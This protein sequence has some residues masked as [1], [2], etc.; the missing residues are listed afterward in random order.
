MFAAVGF[1]GSRLQQIAA[2]A[3]VSEALI[4]RHFPSKTALYRAVLRA[5]VEEQNRAF[6]EVEDLKP[7]A[8]GLVQ[9]LRQV[10]ELSL[11]G[12]GAPNAEALRVL[13]ASLAGDGGHARLAFRRAMRHA[14]PAMEKALAAARASGEVSGEEID[15]ANAVGFI[16]QV[17][18]T[19]QISRASA[20]PVISYSDDGAAL[21][22]QGVWFCGRGLGLT[23]A[24]LERHYP[25][26]AE[27]P[28]LR[29]EPR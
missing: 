18:L 19:T 23:E 27:R 11:R 4:Y 8:A 1:E 12:A 3:G 16:A 24:A 17:A 6:D 26:A 13:F 5:L 22:C 9:M 28:R 14:R 21:V 7:S 15:A 2:A 25:R 20:R 29:P 10:F